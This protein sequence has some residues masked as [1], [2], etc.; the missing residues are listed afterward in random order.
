M[1]K[2]ALW[3]MDLPRRGVQVGGSV[4]LA[5]PD[6]APDPCPKVLAGWTTRHLDWI[7]KPMN[8][9]AASDEFAIRVTADVAAAWQA[10]KS[11]L[12]PVQRNWVQAHL[13]SAADLA[14]DPAWLRLVQGQQVLVES[15]DV[16]P[17]P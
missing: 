5:I 17:E 1:A 12:T 16:E 10:K 9:G 11:Q 2:L 15:E 7:A 8:T 4:R 3:L 14:Q 6:T 13:D